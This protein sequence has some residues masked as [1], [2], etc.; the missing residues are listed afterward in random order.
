[1]DLFDLLLDLWEEANFVAVSE[2]FTKSDHFNI[3]LK[4]LE[5]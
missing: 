3:K 4:S 2:S 5:M 1:M